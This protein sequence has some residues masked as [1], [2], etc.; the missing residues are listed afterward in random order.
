MKSWQ[1]LVDEKIGGMSFFLENTSHIFVSDCPRDLFKDYVCML[2]S[3][4]NRERDP[5]RRIAAFQPFSQTLTIAGEAQPFEKREIKYMIGALG[6]T[7][8][9]TLTVSDIARVF[10]FYPSLQTRAPEQSAA[11][12]K[13]KAVC[14]TDTY[15]R[16]TKYLLA[17]A[18]GARIVSHKWILDSVANVNAFKRAE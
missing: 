14:I 1:Q 3:S 6:G 15:Y 12:R 11:L 2:T 9:D 13:G 16:T 7:F 18:T 8:V 5:S 4:T 17:L 10:T